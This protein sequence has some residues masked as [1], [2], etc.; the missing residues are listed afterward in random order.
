MQCFFEP[1]RFDVLIFL[2]LIAY[3]NKIE[4]LQVMS[5]LWDDEEDRKELDNKPSVYKV[6]AALAPAWT[7]T[8]PKNESARERLLKTA[9]RTESLTNR[10]RTRKVGHT[11]SDDEIDDD[12]RQNTEF[13]YDSLV[14]KDK[15]LFT[16]G[17]PLVASRSAQRMQVPLVQSTLVL[18]HGND[19]NF[20]RRKKPTEVSG[21]TQ[22]GISGL[23][24]DAVWHPSG[25]VLTLGIG[26]GVEVHHTVGK[27]MERL[28]AAELPGGRRLTQVC[29]VSDGEAVVCLQEET[30][31]PTLVQLSTGHT[32][33]LAFMDIRIHASQYSMRVS[34]AHGKVSPLPSALALQK[35]AASA[36][37]YAMINGA[38]LSIG[39]L[40]DGCSIQTI[41][42]PS[43]AEDLL[44]HQASTGT[45]EVVVACGADILVYDLRKSAQFKRKFTD[46]G[47]M[48]IARLCS[49]SSSLIVGSTSGVV[50]VYRGES[51]TPIKAFRNLNT[52]VDMLSAGLNA[53]KEPMLVMASSEQSNGLRCANL[54]S[55]QGVPNFPSVGMRHKFL[56]CLAFN[57]VAPVFTVGEP[58][59][60][61]NYKC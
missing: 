44:L 36:S 22:G 24:R 47:A 48:K 54:T 45:P 29:M 56:Q 11:G 6:S 31:T 14:D 58:Q 20:N 10:K 50:N 37:L 26:R 19:K 17:T 23:L 13:K 16:D 49:I 42:L 32:M 43:T 38:Q 55:L 28:M 25:E 53:A 1:R 57:P 39:S 21:R 40:R 61:I 41:S 7:K 46:E 34:R 52:S 59:R 33:P 3:T 35:E 60:V 8:A 12:N 18:H 9:E 5:S 4:L 27:Q 15:S 51:S 2:Q 30:Y